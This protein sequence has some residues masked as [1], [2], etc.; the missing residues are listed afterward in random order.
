[1][2]TDQTVIM[3]NCERW[4]WLTTL[5]TCEDLSDDGQ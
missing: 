1:M 4:H 5:A 3:I 2:A